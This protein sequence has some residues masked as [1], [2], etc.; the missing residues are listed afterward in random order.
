M[1]GK[2]VSQDDKQ[3]VAVLLRSAKEAGGATNKAAAR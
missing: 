3:R 1:S 2:T